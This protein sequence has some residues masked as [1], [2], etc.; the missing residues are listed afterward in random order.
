MWE[1]MASSAKKGVSEGH[2][3]NLVKQKGVNSLIGVQLEQPNMFDKLLS[4]I[5]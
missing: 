3:V 5:W 4:M 2:I 1:N